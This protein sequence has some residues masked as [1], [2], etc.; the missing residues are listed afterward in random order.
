MKA[1]SRP[2]RP[3][4]WPRVRV[5]DALRLINGRAFKPTEWTTSGVPIVRI[6]NLNNPEAPYNYCQA[7]LPEKF[8]LGDG[9]LLFAWSGTPGTSFGAHIWQ[10]GKAWLNQHIFK[11]LFDGSEWDKRF[12]RL[13]INQNLN[14]YIRQ[15]HGGAG[16]AHITKGRFDASELPKP[17]LHEQRRI[18]AEIEKQFTRLEAGVAALRRVQANL[19]RYRAAVLKAACEGRMVPTEAELARQSG[20]TYETGAQLLAG[21]L[22]ERRRKW[23]GRGKYREPTAP[24]TADLPSL[25]EGWT[26][27]NLD[28]AI[29]S[30]P[31]NGVYLPRELYGRGHPILRIDDY[32]DGWVRD[33]DGLNKVEAD[34]AAANK[35]QLHTGDLVINRVNS[36][37]HLG[38]CL[39]VRE[40]LA[41]A[42]FESNMMKAHLADCV[43][44]RYV[45]FCLR[46]LNGRNRLT[47]GAKWAVNQASINQEDVKRT[48]L[49]LPPLAE[50]DRIVSEVERRL[51]VIEELEAVASV[52]LQRATG[53]RQ[54]ILQMAFR[55]DLRFL[56]E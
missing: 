27:T 26:W 17:E 36:L 50:Q 21:I 29:V 25:P 11:V 31:Q 28:A 15:A 56:K 45:E 5:G 39:I 34:Q 32:Q 42:L 24:D 22:T 8:L 38:K 37:T 19:K 49:P 41:G 51:S 16:L 52:N 47:S 30:G 4:T 12:L 35:Y 33:L 43:E 20:R 48:P 54:S 14:D 18:V 40:A 3:S 9:D 23:T 2:G 10:G 46:S 13:A 6:Q 55:G 1:A 7:D 53:L 44:R